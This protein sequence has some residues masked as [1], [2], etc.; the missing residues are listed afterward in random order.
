M[1]IS[2][3]I[4]NI[5]YNIMFVIYCHIIKLGNMYFAK[6]PTRSGNDLMKIGYCAVPI[7]LRS[8]TAV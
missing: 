2:L 7:L 1:F 4:V 6:I 3:N 8:G 5:Y